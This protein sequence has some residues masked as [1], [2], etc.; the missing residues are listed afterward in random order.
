MDW[1]KKISLARITW[2]SCM[3]YNLL[4]EYDIYQTTH[5]MW[6]A[7]KEKYGRLSDTKLRE[8]VMKCG[9]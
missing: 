2:L 1:K 4:I 7:L 6:E 3:Q 8:L 5:E 9:N